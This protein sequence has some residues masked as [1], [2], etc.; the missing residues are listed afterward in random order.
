MSKL[1]TGYKTLEYIQSSGT[2]SINSGFVPNQDT[3]VVAEFDAGKSM[4]IAVE[5]V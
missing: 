4:V 2:Q 3:R 1:P 5:I